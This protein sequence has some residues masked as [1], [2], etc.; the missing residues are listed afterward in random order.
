[1][2]VTAIRG[3]AAV[4]TW[5]LAL[6]LTFRLPQN[7]AALGVMIAGAAYMCLFNPRAEG[8]TYAML[9]LPCAIVVSSALYHQERA[10]TLWVSAAALLFL[11]GSNGITTATI[12]LTRHWFKPALFVVLF[13]LMAV[14]IARTPNPYRR[15]RVTERQ[16]GTPAATI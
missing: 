12:N 3:A 4:A 1:M 10:R 5:G 9:A 2:L 13:V 16:N 7:A 8:L 11:I 14:A 15:R 6:W